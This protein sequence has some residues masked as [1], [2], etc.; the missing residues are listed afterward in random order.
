MYL[1][2]KP[3]RTAIQLTAMFP[4]CRIPEYLTSD[5]E[6]DETDDDS[7]RTY[8]ESSEEE[9]YQPKTSRKHMT[10]ETT[11]MYKQVRDAQEL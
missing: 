1:L 4:P 7:D 8:D 6:T 11:S 9:E 10:K 5:E 2:V 3:S